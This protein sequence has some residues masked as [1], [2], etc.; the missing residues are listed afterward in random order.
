MEIQKK[1]PIRP[2]L[3]P[4]SLGQRSQQKRLQALGRL[5]EVKSSGLHQRERCGVGRA[6]AMGLGHQGSQGWLHREPK[7][8][9][10]SR[11]AAN[12]DHGVAAA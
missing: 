1:G 7:R 8:R 3:R 9:W 10:L 4:F 11:D 5:S 12:L 2:L 6:V